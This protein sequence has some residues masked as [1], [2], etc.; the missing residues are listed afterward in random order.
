MSATPLKRPATADEQLPVLLEGQEE[1]AFDPVPVRPASRT[2]LGIRVRVFGQRFVAGARRDRV[3]L[4]SA[5]VL[6]LAILAVL[7][8]W[9]ALDLGTAAAEPAPILTNAGTD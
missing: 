1:V 4:L 5:A 3:Q 9:G 2:S 8:S 7:T 6:T